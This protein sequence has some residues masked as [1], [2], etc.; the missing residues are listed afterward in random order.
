MRGPDHSD[1]T[2]ARPNGGA[3]RTYAW[4][5]GDSATRQPGGWISGGAMAASSESHDCPDVSARERIS[6]EL[7]KR[8]RKL[9]WIGREE[10]A[11]ELEHAL[12]L[13]LSAPLVLTLPA[14]TD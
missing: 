14:E 1:R 10:E 5:W 13:S 4:R 8:I 12:R 9:R 11:G 6:N 2:G 3:D 7:V